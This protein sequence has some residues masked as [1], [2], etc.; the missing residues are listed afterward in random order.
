[1]HVGIR[2][3][4]RASIALCWPW[5]SWS[6][7]SLATAKEELSLPLTEELS[8]HSGKMTYRCGRADG[9]GIEELP[10]PLDYPIY[11][12]LEHVK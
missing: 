1:M 2:R 11:D 12:S 7:S 6:Y 4:C 5:E 3:S 9:M 10:L 8:Q